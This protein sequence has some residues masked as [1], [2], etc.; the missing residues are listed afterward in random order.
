MKVIYG[1]LAVV[2]AAVAYKYLSSTPVADAKGG[3]QTVSTARVQQREFPVL[4]ETNGTTV[5]A[6]VVDVRPQVSNVVTQVHVKDGQMVRQGDLLFSLDNRA[7][8]A[9]YEK[10]KAT[11]EDA[12]RQLQRAL[13]LVKQQ[14]IAQSSA[15]TAKS[16]ADAAIAATKAAQAV[17]SYDSIRAPIAG[18]LGIINVFPGT[19]VTP[20]NTVSTTTTSTATT[21]QGA[22][23]TITQ[24]NPIH[25]QF[26]I[27]EA[28]LPN[29]LAAQ[30]AGQELTVQFEIAGRQRSGKVFVIDNQVDASVGTVKAKAVIDNADHSLIPGQFVKLSLQAGKIND[31]LVVPSQ[32][33]VM[34]PRGEQIYV[35]KEDD[36]VA[37][38]PVK[39]RAQYEGETVVSGVEAGQRVVVEGKQNLRPSVKIRE[40]QAAKAAA[41]PASA[42]SAAAVQASGVSASRP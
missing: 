5:A 1:L 17:L 35:V 6:T 29:V 27:P 21:A 28:Q 38:M 14:F 4:I 39:I 8:Q 26:T 12:K 19:L 18:R 37:L 2:I 30:Q 11:E 42:A 13:E 9:N 3:M 7:D 15:D 22:M 16:N 31:A 36:T 23:A 41:T 24:L 10:A 33:V 32:S 40:A 34:T 25:V 20:G